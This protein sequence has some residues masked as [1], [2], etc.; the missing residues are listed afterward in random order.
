MK[1]TQFAERQYEAAVQLELAFG[2]V[3]PFVPAQSI[4]AYIGIDGAFDPENAHAIWRILSVQIPRRV[5]LSPILW[6]SLPP[7]FHDQI[8]GRLCSLFLQFK[9]PTFQ[10]GSHSLYR[11]RLGEPYFEV[12]ITPHQ[13]TALMQLQSRVRGKAVVRYASPAFW[14]RSDFDL[15][16]QSRKILLKSAFVCP[17]RVKNHRRWMYTPTLGRVLLN[18]DPEEMPGEG[19][20]EIIGVMSEL[21]TAESLRSHVQALAR[22]LKNDLDPETIESERFWLDRLSRYGRFSDDDQR[23]LVDLSR[24]A[25]SAEAANCSWWVML[26]PKNGWHR[27]LDIPWPRFWHRWW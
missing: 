3:S 16:D 25:I 11:T 27:I 17:S 18:P 2:G 9:R 4:E 14:S 20:R 19:W 23:F 26:E 12:R 7:Q 21:A 24:I 5:T 10:D 1:K 22:E 6:P 8:P 13:Q 15:Y